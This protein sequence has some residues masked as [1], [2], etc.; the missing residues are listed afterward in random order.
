MKSGQASD[1]EVNGAEAVN[2]QAD[3]QKLGEMIKDIRI[4]M[5]TTMDEQGVLHSRPMATQQ[6]EFDGDV[7]FFT[8]QETG[9]VGDITEYRQVNLAYV[10]TSDERYVS[11]M[12]N[13]E[14]INDVFKMK[15]LWKPVMKAWFPEGLDDPNLRL[16][17]VSAEKAE[18]WESNGGKAGSLLS[19][20]K[21]LV[22]GSTGA[23]GKNEKIT[24]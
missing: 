4:A 11:V 20:V 23:E 5:L 8:S 7:W 6:V 9:K 22:T 1:N 2:R 3:V 21:N 17:R 10:S 16:I 24:L 19:I 18:Y 13:A 12:G 15:A 14:I